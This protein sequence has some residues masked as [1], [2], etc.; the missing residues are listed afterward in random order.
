MI[1]AG[2]EELIDYVESHFFARDYP[3]SERE[4]IVL[5]TQLSSQRARQF[6]IIF[7]RMRRKRLDKHLYSD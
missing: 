4:I 5:G 7:R 6:P 1:A 2:A 3:K